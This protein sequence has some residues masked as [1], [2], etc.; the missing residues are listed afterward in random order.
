MG[1][2]IDYDTLLPPDADDL[3]PDRLESVLEKV[4]A[5]ALKQASLEGAALIRVAGDDG[6][7]FLTLEEAAAY[8]QSSPEKEESDLKRNLEKALREDPR[9]LEKEIQIVLWLARLTL[10]KYRDNALILPEEIRRVE[11][12]L[13]RLAR[14][15]HYQLKKL[16]ECSHKI[17]ELRQKHPILTEF[18]QKVIQLLQYQKA[19]DQDQ[20]RELAHQLGMIKHQYLRFSRGIESDIQASNILR[21]DLQRQKKSI[22]SC[23]RYLAAQREGRLQETSHGLRKNINSLKSLL[24]KVHEEKKPMVTQALGAQSRKFMDTQQEIQLVQKEQAVLKRQE[25][26]TERLIHTMARILNQ[27]AKG[28]EFKSSPIGSSPSP[29][30]GAVRPDAPISKRMVIMESQKKR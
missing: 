27:S 16:R 25:S 20:A 18:E 3:T 5:D 28:M 21:L 12:Q 9:V 24:L 2:T 11:P 14:Q 4:I 7:R 17:K 13:L 22:L 6:I 8:V 26:E 23:H 30:P 15:V 10:K 29:Q 1:F 19:G